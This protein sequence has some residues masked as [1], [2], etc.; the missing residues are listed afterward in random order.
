MIAPISDTGMRLSDTFG[1]LWSNLELDHENPS[2]NLVEKPCKHL[3]PFSGK[4]LA[5]LVGASLAALIIMHQQRVSTQFLFPSY[6]NEFK[7]NGNSTS[8]ALNKWLKQYTEQGV[9]HSFRNSFR[10]SLRKAEVDIKLTDQLGGWT[11]S[12]ISQSYDAGHIL[13]LK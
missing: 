11:S 13:K 1:L 5:P 7:C 12:S 8:A 3:K 2:I 6:T 9:I 4:R 10:D